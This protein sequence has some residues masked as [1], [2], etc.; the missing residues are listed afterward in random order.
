[1]L[2]DLEFSEHNKK[3]GRKLSKF[4]NPKQFLNQTEK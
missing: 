1:M 3:Q 4:Y 2:D